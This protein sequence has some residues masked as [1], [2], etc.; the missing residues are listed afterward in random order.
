MI[1]SGCNSDADSTDSSRRMVSATV[2]EPKIRTCGG[3]SSKVNQAGVRT[4]SP[5]FLLSSRLW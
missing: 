4:F 1:A 5:L 2:E 3:R